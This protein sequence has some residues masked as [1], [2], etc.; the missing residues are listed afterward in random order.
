[1]IIHIHGIICL[2]STLGLEGL[3]QAED[4]LHLFWMLSIS[5]IHLFPQS[6]FC[7]IPNSIPSFFFQSLLNFLLLDVKHPDNRT[8]SLTSLVRSLDPL[9]VT[10]PL[11]WSIFIDLFGCSIKF[12]GA[13]HF[14][15]SIEERVGS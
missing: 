14:L 10:K 15:L 12:T 8:F 13:F 2:H 5:M 3:G 11:V 4:L 1:M 9:V 6:V 7:T